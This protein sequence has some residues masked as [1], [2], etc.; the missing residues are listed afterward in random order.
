MTEATK[1]IRSA[2]EM[3]WQV[4]TDNTGQYIIY[5]NVPEGAPEDAQVFAFHRGYAMDADNYGNIVLYT[6]LY[7]TTEGEKH[8]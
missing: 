5:T 8:A 1:M 4:E 6:G 2:E 3:G 7:S